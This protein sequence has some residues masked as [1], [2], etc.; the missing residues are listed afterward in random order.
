MNGVIVVD[1]PAGWTSHDV[2]NKM[3]RIA[4]TR[5]IGHL[6]TLDPA[7][8]GVLPLLIERA[9][10]LAQFFTHNEK[11]YEGTIRFG[12]STTSY[13]SE[14]APTSPQ[15]EVAP[16]RDE[17]ERILAT[18][19][20]ATT[21]MPP[22]VS[23][24]K[25]NGRPAH[26]L[27]RKNIPFEL[28]PVE[29]TLFALDLLA[30]DGAVATVRVHCSG[31]TYVRS[32]AHDAGQALGCGAHLS[33][34]RR[35]RSGGFSIEQARTLDECAALAAENRLSEALIPASELL[36]EFPTEIVDAITEAQIRQGRDFRVSPFRERDNAA[37]V[38]AV[39]RAGELIAIGEAVLPNVYHPL[40]VL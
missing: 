12:W 1:K 10:R 23:A 37:R 33:S 34:L 26:E 8:T 16:A 24:K 20:Q 30:L 29:V 28:K 27:V 35:L 31:G 39:S 17:V 3:R 40:L 14:S 15:V 22:P 36:P 21:Q 9:T 32:I 18:L 11:L 13:D 2:V 25:I 4:A 5:K 38:K 19:R 6:G 7:A